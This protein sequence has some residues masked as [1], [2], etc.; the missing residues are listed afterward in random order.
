M[1]TKYSIFFVDDLSLEVVMHRKTTTQRIVLLVLLLSLLSLSCYAANAPKNIVLMIGDGM[2]VG[3]ITAAR[4][5]GPGTNGRLAM[6]TMPVIGLAKTHPAKSLVTDSAASATALATGVKTNNGTLSMDP[7]GKTLRTILEAAHESGRST[8]IVST[9]FIT[10]ATPAAFVSHVAS[11]SQRTDIADQMISSR[12]DI[13]LGGGRK[14]FVT[15]TETCDGRTDGR[16]LLGEAASKGFKVISSRDEMMEVTSGKVLGLFVSDIMTAE[17]PEPTLQEMTQC[18]LNCLDDNKKGFFLMSEGGTIDSNEHANNADGAVK[19]TLEFD[20]AISLVLDFAKKRRDTL[21]VVTADH[22]TGG[23]GVL[24]ADEDHPKFTAG[25][26]C[27]GHTGNMVPIF[28]Y[29]PGS[30]FFSGVHDNTDI[31]K[32]FSKLW[33]CKL[34]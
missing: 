29:G 13:I 2:G 23:M 18:A 34:N 12:V 5:A 30:E 8:G 32:I 17:S 15:K 1:G 16:N 19:Q 22:E 28:A 9:K 11:R 6:D 21:V 24:N 31:P 14:D 3:V 7:D 4:C 20:K 33:K 25:W 10:D 26:I 27:G